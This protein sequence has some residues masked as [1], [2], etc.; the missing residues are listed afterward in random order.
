MG[1]KPASHGTIVDSNAHR[2]SKQSKHAGTESEETESSEEEDEGEDNGR[3]G[4]DD[5]VED[6]REDQN[7]ADASNAEPRR[8]TWPPQR[9]KLLPANAFRAPSD[10]NQV[11]YILQDRLLLTTDIAPSSCNQHIRATSENPQTIKYEP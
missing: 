7:E 5:A 11:G 1:P 9:V 6:T 2:Q 10:V 8:Q 4:A 3:K